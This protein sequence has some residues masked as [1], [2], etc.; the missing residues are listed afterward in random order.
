MPFVLQKV[1]SA[2]RTR[3]AFP[4]RYRWLPPV[5]TAVSGAALVAVLV[6]H[7]QILAT[8]AAACAS[9]IAAFVWGYSVHGPRVPPWREASRFRRRQ[10]A[11]TWNV[12]AS[13]RTTA[14]IAAA[15]KDSEQGLQES[16]AKPIQNLVDLAPFGP[17]SD[18]LEIA[19]GIGRIGK[20][21]GPRCRSWTGADISSNMLGYAAERLKGIPNVRLQRLDGTGLTGLAD[22]SFDLVYCTN[23][24]AHFDELD[25]WR[26]VQEAFRVLRSGGRI[27]IDN[28]DLASDEGW[29]S[30]LKSVERYQGTE[31]PPFMTRFST[32][33]ELVE[34][35]TRAGFEQVTPHRRA[36]LIIVTGVKAASFQSGCAAL[37]IS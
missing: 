33:A 20:E 30:F 34:Y 18:V 22:N 32:S 21:L 17:Q 9:A 29:S 31:Q 2:F 16:A 35:A 5:A 25:R 15:G 19:C 8:L 26:Y 36:P 4:H 27:F 3:A 24:F 28:I 10:Y 11:E 1:Y 12:L 13:A 7:L 37:P 14:G 6:F 23:A